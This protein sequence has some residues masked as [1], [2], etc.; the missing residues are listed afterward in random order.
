MYSERGVTRSESRAI[1][2][3]AEPAR[4]PASQDSGRVAACE[5]RRIGDCKIGAGQ[6]QARVRQQS[7]AKTG[8]GP[9][10]H[11][12]HS[13]SRGGIPENMR[14]ALRAEPA[15]RAGNSCA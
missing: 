3:L 8:A 12:Q 2:W 7:E 11:N 14:E 13:T 6:G 9:E 10:L 5:E 15:G 4:R 1:P